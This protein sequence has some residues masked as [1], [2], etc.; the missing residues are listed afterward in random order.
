MNDQDDICERDE[1]Q[2]DK[3]LLKCEHLEKYHSAT[4]LLYASKKQ[5]TLLNFEKMLV[6]SV[7]L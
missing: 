2:S 7:D 4:D 6:N 3:N 1:A 5:I